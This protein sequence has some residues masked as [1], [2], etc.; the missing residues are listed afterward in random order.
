MNKR[1]VAVTFMVLIM[2]LA[3]ACGGG[4]APAD[5]DGGSQSQP[6][7]GGD[8]PAAT[9]EPKTLQFGIV[10][11]EA[12]PQYVAVARF[13]EIIEEKSGGNITFDI[14]ADGAL[15]GEREMLEAIQTGNLDI[16][17]ISSVV[18]ANFDQRMSIIDLPFLV[19]NFDEAEA[20]MDGP[21]GDALK[22]VMLEN[23]LRVLGWG[24]NDFRTMSNSKRPIR[25]VEDMDGLKF[26]VP[27][28]PM[29]VNFFRNT[30]AVPTPMPWPEVYAALQQGAID[31]QDNGPGITY[32]SKVYE[33]QK[34]I[35]ATNHQYGPMALF[36]SDKVWQSLTEEERQ[37]FEEAGQQAVL[38]ERQAVREYYNSSL[39]KME[40]EGLEIIRELSPEA[41][42]GFREAALPLYEN[43]HEQ[44]G[45][46]L[47]EMVFRELG[48]EF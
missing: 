1:L 8:T 7:T 26:R 18:Y 42:E 17:F 29:L 9:S 13:A 10:I 11:G 23:N 24:H 22:E 12:T 6:S 33:V 47:A 15:G 48:L 45:A 37:W 21:V 31:G 30:G 19:S 28:T 14:F 32:G 41:V 20:L 27:E 2:L 34:Y 35:T 43:I 5:G 38:E 25:T 40:E 16:G 44:V 36:V 39:D 46:E 4:G 3:V